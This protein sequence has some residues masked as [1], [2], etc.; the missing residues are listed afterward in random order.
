M[1]DIAEALPSTP[2]SLSIPSTTDEALRKFKCPECTKAFKFKHHLKEHIRIHSGEKPFECQQCHKRFSHSGSYSSHMSSKKCVQAASPSMVTP[3]NPY[4]LMMYRNLMLQLQTPQVSFLPQANNMENAYMSLLQANILQNLENGGSPTAT[5]PPSS[6]QEPSTPEPKVEVVDEPEEESTTAEK[7]PE[8]AEVVVKSEEVSVSEESVTPAVSVSVSVSVSPTLEQNGNDLIGNG[9]DGK[10]SPDWRPLRS[11]SFLNDSQVAI[12]QNHFKRNPFPSKYELSAVAEQIGVNKRVVQVWFQNTR[13]KERRSNRL[14][15]MPRGSSAMAPTSPTVWQT[16]A[17]LMAVWAQQCLQNGNNSLSSNSQ[18]E[19]S[20]LRNN[21]N[22]VADEEVMDHDGLLG[23]K[24]G[25]ETP[26]DLTLSTEDTEPEW[27]P[28]KLIGFLDQTGGVIQELLRQAGN[29]FVTNQE[30]EEEKPVKAEESPVSSTSSSI[31]PS[32]IGQY[33]SI[34][35]SAS[36]SALE[37]ALDQQKSSEDD[38]SSLCSNESKLLKFSSTPLKE[39]EGLFSCDQ[40]DKVFGKQSS[41]ARHKYEHSGQ[42]PY[43]CDICEKAF[44]HKH[45]LTEHKRLHSG[46]KPFQCDK[47]LKRFSHSGSYSQH[48]NHRY[49]YCKPYR[50]QPGAT[51]PKSDVLNGSLTVSPSSSNTPP[52]N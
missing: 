20:V 5:S 14:P 28:E 9:S 40:C 17:Q 43:K 45:H 32:F 11:R 2:T 12:L 1:V 8:E 37:K 30:E 13:A 42:R 23:S 16:P 27:S 39:E 29:G 46:E 26:L 25:K 21:E 44:K 4:Q 34:L 22:R 10:A 7:T 15:S 31:W 3:F 36:L 35:D 51:S 18:D 47:C 24:D 6:V 52:P 50:E 38:A 48:M 33:P 49:S 41:L 19:S